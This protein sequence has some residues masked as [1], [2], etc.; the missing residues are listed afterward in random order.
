MCLTLAGLVTFYSYNLISIVLEHNAQLGN[1]QLRFRDMA[2]DILGPGWGRFFVDPL[3]FGL[4]YGTVI[5]DVLLAGQSLKAIYLLNKADGRMELYQF[6]IIFGGLMLIL[7]QMPSFHSLRYINLAC[8]IFNVAYSA[9]TTAG[10]IHIEDSRNAP[11]KDYRATTTGV[12]RVFGI[13]NAISIISTTY[14]NGIVPEIQAT[15]APP[16]KGKMFKGLLLCYAAAILTFFSVAISGY[17]AFGN[18]SQGNVLQNFI[19]NGQPLMPKW[20]LV[21]ANVLILLHIIPSA[22]TYLQPTNVVLERTF[23]DPNKGQFSFRN[24]MPRI[25]FR[26]LSI[27]VATLLA[28]MLPFFGDLVALLGAFSC[29]P[30]DFIL[31]MVFYNVTFKPSKKTIIFWVN[32]SIAVISTMLSLIGA[33]ASVRQIVLDAKTYRLFSNV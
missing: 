22:L 13:F 4:C 21:M 27:V 32:T 15:L 6:V 10:S 1:R 11:P 8:L 24:A 20:F 23:V 19:V 28:A 16:I 2:C 9:C 5:A 31:P 18:K 29:I 26:S 25:I 33:V 3:Q 30:L 17:W 12:D 7:A 14:G